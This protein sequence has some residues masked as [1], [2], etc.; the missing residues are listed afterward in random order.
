VGEDRG[1]GGGRA[2]RG[3]A[4]ICTHVESACTRTDICVYLVCVEG[5]RGRVGGCV[6]DSMISR[7]KL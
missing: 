4:Y 6:T 2:G 1:D 5:W 7:P 3:H